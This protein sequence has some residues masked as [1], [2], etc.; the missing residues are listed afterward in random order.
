MAR[1]RL[2]L[3]CGFSFLLAS[4]SLAQSPPPPPA[5]PSPSVLSAP[6]PTVASDVQLWTLPD[7]KCQVR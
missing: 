3:H 1:V 6:A 2:L 4:L 5:S 7:R